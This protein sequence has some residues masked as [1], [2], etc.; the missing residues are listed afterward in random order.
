[1]ASLESKSFQQLRCQGA[2]I[3][4]V[5]ADSA[6]VFGKHVH[7]QFGLGL[8]A[9]GAQ[10][11]SSGRG[12]IEAGAGDIIT[13]N[14]EEVH[15]GR[16]IGEGGRH[17]RMLYLSPSLV[18]EL[19]DDI[20]EGRASSTQEFRHPKLSEP[21]LARQFSALFRALTDSFDPQELQADTGL[22]LLLSQVLQTRPATQTGV[23]AGIASARERIDDE[24]LAALT[25]GALAQ[26]AGLS[27]F[28][29][30][31]GFKRLTGLT[32]HAYLLQRRLH[33]ARQLIARGTG[34]A[35]AAAQSG[36]ADQ[37]HMSRI[38]ARSFGL[39][40]AAYARAMR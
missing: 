33:I 37:S 16:P 32:P 13:V 17:W 31:R 40:P 24:P 19:A 21:P 35:D 25:L 4:A 28:Q 7:T 26:Q 2:G 1:M 38:F 10:R 29:F 36:F 15:D 3:D 18:A 27:R 6:R 39:A 34:L 5:E 22:L 30:L 11:S 8:I 12:L 9:R 14:P 20:S 23:S